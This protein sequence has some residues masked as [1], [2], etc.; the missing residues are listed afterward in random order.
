MQP[1]F[2]TG[3]NAGD[4]LFTTQKECC[5]KWFPYDDNCVNQIGE[6]FYPNYDSSNTCSKKQIKNFEAYETER[7]DTLEECCFTK[8]SSAGT[9][10]CKT[11]DLI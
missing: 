2:M 3:D 9:Y 5:N 7:Y 8:V 1:T 11:I 6:K 4:Y 10:L